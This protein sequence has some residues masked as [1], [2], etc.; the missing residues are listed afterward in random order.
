MAMFATSEAWRVD[1][2]VLKSLDNFP[3]YTV[4]PAPEPKTA[5]WEDGV[6]DIPPA[7]LAAAGNAV[8]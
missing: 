5:A 2:Q 6:P 1:Q 8:S 7:G 3:L 4:T